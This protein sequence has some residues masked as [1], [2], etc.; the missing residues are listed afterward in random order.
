MA[1]TLPISRYDAAQTALKDTQLVWGTKQVHKGH[2]NVG[3]LKLR[4]EGPW[5]PAVPRRPWG[6]APSP[7]TCPAGPASP[8]TCL[9]GAQRGH[10]HPWSKQLEEHRTYGILPLGCPK[11][12]LSLVTVSGAGFQGKRPQPSTPRSLC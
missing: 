4:N 8:S 3:G 2:F 6:G 12:L 10:S 7:Q 1:L 9:L 5:A 11:M